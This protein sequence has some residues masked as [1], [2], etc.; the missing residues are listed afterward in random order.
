MRL[1]EADGGFGTGDRVA[2]RTLKSS[3]RGSVALGFQD[4]IPG[5]RLGSGLLSADRQGTQK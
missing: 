3:L 4:S 5:L 1:A 2:R